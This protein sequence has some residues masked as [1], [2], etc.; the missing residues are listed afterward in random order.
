MCKH[1]LCLFLSGG[2]TAFDRGDVKFKVFEYPEYFAIFESKWFIWWIPT[3]SFES[4]RK[5]E[6]LKKLKNT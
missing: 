3:G 4:W 1:R 6:L 2:K 5:R